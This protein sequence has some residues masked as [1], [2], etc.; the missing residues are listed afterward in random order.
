MAIYRQELNAQTG[1]ESRYQVDS[2]EEDRIRAR[3]TSN[4]V[5]QKRKNLK[6]QFA[7]EAKARAATHEGSWSTLDALESVYDAW[8]AIK[9]VATSAQQ[10]AVSNYKY[11]RYSAAEQVDAVDATD[12][13]KIVPSSDAPFNDVSDQAGVDHPKWPNSV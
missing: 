8:P 9:S 10:T 7:D 3:W 5:A 2:A 4:S 11:Y 13:D 1:S 12:L 6:D